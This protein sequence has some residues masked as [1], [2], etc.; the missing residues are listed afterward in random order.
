LFPAF[1]TVAVNCAV[2]DSH[3]V[4]FGNTLVGAP[5]SLTPTAGIVTEADPA[6]PEVGVAVTVK[7][8]GVVPDAGAVYNPLELIVPTA[9]APLSDQV[10]VWLA[11]NC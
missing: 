6:V 9:P 11:A 1:A 2:C 7:L 4:L 8:T 3:P 10:T 5:E